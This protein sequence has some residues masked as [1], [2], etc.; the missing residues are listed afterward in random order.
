MYDVKKA[1]EGSTLSAQERRD[2][3]KTTLEGISKMI[4]DL[5]K[6]CRYCTTCGKHYFK[7]EC[8]IDS[9]KVKKTVCANPLTGGYL[10]PY[11]YEE[12]EVTEFCN[13]CPEGHEMGG[14]VEWLSCL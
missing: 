11:E 10:D 2:L 3:L 12:Q 4:D 6:D 9:R 8:H 5:D 14:Y 13:I 7:K 1:F